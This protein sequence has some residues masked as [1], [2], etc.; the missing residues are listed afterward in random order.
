[1]ME[2]RGFETPDLFHAIDSRPVWW[3]SP[4]PGDWSRA[5]ALDRDF[6]RGL[7]NSLV[8]SVVVRG[9]DRLGSH[10]S[11]NRTLARFDSRPKTP[12]SAVCPRTSRTSL[13]RFSPRCPTP[14]RKAPTVAQQWTQGRRETFANDLL[15]LQTNPASVNSSKADGDAATWL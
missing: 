15:N 10:W 6:A 2:L 8:I 1:M 3:T 4:E 9:I 14:G 5:S 11:D 12:T 7:V 13:I